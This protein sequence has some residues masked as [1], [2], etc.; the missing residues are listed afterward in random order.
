MLWRWHW[1]HVLHCLHAHV[2]YRG[3]HGLLRL[4]FAVPSYSVHASVVRYVIATLCIGLFNLSSRVTHR[5]YRTCTFRPG[6]CRTAPDSGQDKT[7]TRPQLS[8]NV[9]IV[10]LSVCY[11]V[12]RHRSHTV[13]LAAQFA[14]C[15]FDST[16]DTIKWFRPIIFSVH[17]VAKR[18]LSL[19]AKV[20]EYNE[21]VNRKLPATLVL[22]SW[23]QILDCCRYSWGPNRSII[24]AQSKMRKCPN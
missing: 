2:A 17:F 8:L 4:I 19:I 22:I 3:M 12:C 18:Y 20:F 15:V 7:E 1:L 10:L 9:P 16:V 13:P 11:I 24:G 5:F 21:E 14:A 23:P 6:C